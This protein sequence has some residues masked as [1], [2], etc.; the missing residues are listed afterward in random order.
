MLTIGL[1]WAADSSGSGQ[2][3]PPANETF[4]LASCSGIACMGCG[5]GCYDCSGL[6]LHTAACSFPT[7]ALMMYDDVIV[8]PFNINRRGAISLL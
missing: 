7:D 8:R 3:V 1:T 4:S 5:P 6:N 2:S